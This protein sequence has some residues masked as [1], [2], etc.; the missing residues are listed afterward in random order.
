M[1]GWRGGRER[2]KREGW[3]RMVEKK[4]DAKGRSVRNREGRGGKREGGGEK[5]EGCYS[6]GTLCCQYL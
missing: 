1:N 6:D 3:I 4:E 5:G 2:R